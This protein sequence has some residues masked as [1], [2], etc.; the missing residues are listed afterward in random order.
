MHRAAD[1]QDTPARTSIWPLRRTCQLR[2]SHCAARLSPV[3]R[4][5]AMPP[6]PTAMQPSAAG[7]ETLASKFALG[8]GSG[9]ATTCQAVPS[10]CSVRTW[11]SKSKLPTAMQLAALR[12]ETPARPLCCVPAGTAAASTLQLCPSQRSATGWLSGRPAANCSP[13]AMQLL[14]LAHEIPNNAVL[15]A[16]PSDGVA[17]TCQLVPSHA[18][19]S[20][21][22]G[23]PGEVGR[24]DPTAMQLVAAVHETADSE[25]AA[26]PGTVGI[27]SA[28][29]VLPS[30]I[31][32]AAMPVW[33]AGLPTAMHRAGVV[34]EMPRRL[35]SSGAIASSR[36]RCP[37]QD[38]AKG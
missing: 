15:P 16:V 8:N 26:A 29:Q 22:L 23:L 12:H 34:Q 24:Y 18:S 25:A 11:F 21:T 37:S 1:G 31:C 14:A 4:P 17:C 19:A 32:A 28:C 35:P 6:L 3:N 27:A 7:Q 5:P 2:P 38:N 10:Q 9:A 13:T 36:Q 33:L 20:G 30:H